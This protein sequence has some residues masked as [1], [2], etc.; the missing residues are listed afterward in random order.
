MNFNTIENY[1][2]NTP[3][4]HQPVE[5]HL[6]RKYLIGKRNNMLDNNLIN[7][8]IDQI[9]LSYIVKTPDQLGTQLQRYTFDKLKNLKRFYIKNGV[10]YY[11]QTLEELPEDLIR[12]DI[13][14]N[15]WDGFAQCMCNL[16]D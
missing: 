7:E 12:C 8:L 16:V 2:L 10:I 5:F 3:K 13:C 1:I 9:P 6:Y 4:F 11:N 15:V 14:G